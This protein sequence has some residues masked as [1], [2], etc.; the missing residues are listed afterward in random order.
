MQLGERRSNTFSSLLLHPS[1]LIAHHA[2]DA[3]AVSPLFPP[4]PPL[5]LLLF[6]LTLSLT[7]THTGTQ[8]PGTSPVGLVT[9]SVWLTVLN[10]R[11]NPAVMSEL[12][13][14]THLLQPVF[15]V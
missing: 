14:V 10:V 9:L 7:Y 8:I 13:S 1:S 12:C 3:R 15:S 5:F 2:F 6:S 11:L 4:P